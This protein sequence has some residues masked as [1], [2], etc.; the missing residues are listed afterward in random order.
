LLI[1]DKLS[2]QWCICLYISI[3]VDKLH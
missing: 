1:L 3:L 2:D